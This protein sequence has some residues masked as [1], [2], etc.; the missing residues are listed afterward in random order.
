[1]KLKDNTF[2]FAYSCYTGESWHDYCSADVCL[3]KSSDNGLSWSNPTVVVKNKAQ[4][5]ISVS[6]LR[7]KDNRIA[8]VYLEKSLVF[9]GTRVD[10]RPYI[11]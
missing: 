9:D 1:M 6:L 2:V 5:V 7:L 4:N 8:L 11:I 10:C 3:I